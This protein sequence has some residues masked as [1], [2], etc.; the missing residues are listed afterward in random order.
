M[1]GPVVGVVCALRSEARHLGRRVYGQGLVQA[2][3][4][5]TLRVVSGM[6]GT[7]AA[8]GAE[9]LIAAGA[10]ALVS[11]G[12]A[13]G[14]DPELP[15]GLI[16]LP[17]EILA[18]DGALLATDTPWRERLAA[19]LGRFSPLASGRLVTSVAA[20]GTVAAKAALFKRSGARAVD[21]E[22]A[23]VA[24]VARSRD[25]PFL[26]IRV[27]IDRAVDV[28]PDSLL[29]AIAAGGEFSLWRLLAHLA[30]SP[31]ELAPF[32]RLART[33]SQANRSLAAAAASG[34]LAPQQSVSLGTG[35]CTAGAS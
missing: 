13:G 33:H 11:W 32:V 35:P 31:A 27:I 17:S 28:L 26:A 24:Q 8:A 3:A 5:G 29:A 7:L 12:L 14:L 20:V 25:L 21:M 4:P 2:V 1:T 34:A 9:R 16:F 30:R 22:S 10:G 15:V 23:S 19:A 18:P 6:G